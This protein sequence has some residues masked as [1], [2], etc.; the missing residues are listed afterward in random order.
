VALGGSPVEVYFDD[1]NV[2]QVKSPVIQTEDYYPFGLTF[3]SYRRENNVQ[4]KHLFNGGSELE[5]D[6]NLGWYSTL[7]RTYD[8]AIG[9]FLQIDLMADFFPGNTPYNFAANNPILFGDPTGLAPTLWQRVKAFF[10][11]GRLSGTRAA[12]NQAYVK[13]AGRNKAEEKPYYFK[14]PTVE[15]TPI[16]TAQKK[17]EPAPTTV[18]QKQDDDSTTPKFRIPTKGVTLLT[19]LK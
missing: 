9:R 17:E 12:G 2:E 8:P 13:P 14:L 18:V 6:L 19:T 4:N 16:K 1:F 15:D 3:N 10:G 7:F 5:T 11:I